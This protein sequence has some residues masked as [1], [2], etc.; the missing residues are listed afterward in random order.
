M[1]F[2]FSVPLVFLFAIFFPVS[3]VCVSRASTRGSVLSEA[4][5]DNCYDVFKR[6]QPSSL[7]PRQHIFNNA[8]GD[9]ACE[10]MYS[11]LWSWAHG[12]DSGPVYLVFMWPTLI[13][14]TGEP[15]GACLVS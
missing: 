3:L 13:R 6:C 9:E 2:Y 5:H 7:T 12:G 10:A 14:R 15:A 1:F 11:G 4:N 8:F